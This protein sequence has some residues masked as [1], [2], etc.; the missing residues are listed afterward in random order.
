M[1][2][3]QLGARS[4]VGR[5]VLLSCRSSAASELCQTGEA[6][7]PLSSCL[8]HSCGGMA[9]DSR[10]MALA[11]HCPLPS[12]CP[13]LRLGPF[14]RDALVRIF[15]SR[16]GLAS[17][18]LD[19]PGTSIP[20]LERSC[21]CYGACWRRHPHRGAKPRYSGRQELPNAPLPLDAWCGG[22]GAKLAP[23]WNLGTPF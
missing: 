13:T 8:C 11:V 4:G 9:I 7:L 16:C 21:L 2:I 20:S 5:R 14:A 1:P 19:R 3:S 6:D 12:S 23:S 15:H 22:V 17:S 18:T 10:L